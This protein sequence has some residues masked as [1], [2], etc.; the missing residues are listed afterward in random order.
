[1]NK[2]MKRACGIIAAAAT[3]AAGLVGGGYRGCR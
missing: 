1:M 2:L 3:L